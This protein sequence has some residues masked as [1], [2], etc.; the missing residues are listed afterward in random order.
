[1]SCV[2]SVFIFIFNYWCSYEVPVLRFVFLRLLYVF[3]ATWVLA[4]T[5]FFGAFV[6]RVYVSAVLFLFLFVQ[7]LPNSVWKGIFVS[8]DAQQESIKHSDTVKEVIDQ[9][10]LVY[11]C[12][13]HSS[14]CSSCRLDHT[15]SFGFFG[16]A[17]TSFY[18]SIAIQ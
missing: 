9:S 1:M 18:R 11:F 8:A 4:E 13:V 3:R 2:T 15:Q 12:P 6:F 14:N 5:V 7:E 16:A 17:T 10:T